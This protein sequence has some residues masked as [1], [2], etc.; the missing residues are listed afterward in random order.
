[1]K[2]NDVGILWWAKFFLYFSDK[3]EMVLFHQSV[4]RATVLWHYPSV[5]VP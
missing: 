1:M 4:W 3:I 5:A 2:K